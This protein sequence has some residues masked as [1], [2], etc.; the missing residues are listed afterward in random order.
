MIQ[1]IKKAPHE[2]GLKDREERLVFDYGADLEP[3]C[4]TR[5]EQSP[6]PADDGPAKK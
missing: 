2:A 6:E 1:S 3:W 4:S 5:P